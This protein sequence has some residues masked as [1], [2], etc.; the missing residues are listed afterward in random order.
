MFIT[1]RTA[2]RRP[3]FL[4]LTLAATI[5]AWSCCD[6]E[7]ALASCGDYV[8]VGG[9]SHSSEHT[10][11]GVPTCHGPHCQKQVPLPLGPGKSLVRAGSLDAAFWHAI[12]G[13]ANGSSS[14]LVSEENLSLADGH[15]WPLLRPPSL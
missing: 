12:A 7:V 8:M 1:D 2:C 6:T 13:A 5:T 15:S 3:L 11:P 9:H 10:A 4:G 14:G